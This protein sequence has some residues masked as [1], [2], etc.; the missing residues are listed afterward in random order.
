MR[1]RRRAFAGA[2]LVAAACV[3]RLTAP[4]RCPD[5]CP[6]GAITVLDTLLRTNISKDSAYRGYVQPWQSGLVL[7]ANLPGTDSRPV[8]LF[9]SYGPGVTLKSGDT[10][11][12]PIQRVDSARLQF[13]LLRRD[14]A[15]HN[16][17]VR[18]YRLPVTIDTTTTF[19][20]LVPPF[21][22]SLL[23]TVNIDSLLALPGR[24]DSATGDSIKVDPITHDSVVVDS[25]HHALVSL[26]LDSSQARYVVA[27]TGKVAYGIRISADSLATIALG[28]G[29]LGPLYQPYVTIDSLGTPVP[30]TG[31]VRGTTVPTFVFSP[32]P[33]PL[34]ST[35]AVGGMPSARSILRVAFPR[36]IRDSA[37]V[38]RGTLLLV[39]AV[40]ARGAP[41]DSFVIEAHAAVADFGA[42]SPLVIDATRTDTAV[43]RVGATDTV[44]IEITNLLQLWQSDTTRA[45]SIV[46]TAKS[47]GGDFAEIR[48]Y[49][50]GAAL[51]R[52]A[53]R[54][55]YVPRFPFGKP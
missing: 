41:V 51:Y 38:I 12:G 36:A 44:H 33:P 9:S 24:R 53:I 18:L 20:T 34:D 5:Y 11:T 43:I 4:G 46:L 55:T 40:A 15:A 16:L 10:T 3:E 8:F 54:L 39:P 2:A 13:H 1:G 19:A 35:L 6:S 48:F 37:Q 49:P 52:P 50:S 27:D 42:Q 17:T 45:E 30:R 31:P 47:E 21:T 14:T 29:D 25:T 7:A 23:R 22:D 32:P 28:K 26:R